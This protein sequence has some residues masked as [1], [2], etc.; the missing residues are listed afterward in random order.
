MFYDGSKR[1][2]PKLRFAQTYDSCVDEPCMRLLFTLSAA[3]GLIVMDADC[4]NACANAPS[5][6]QPPYVRFDRC[7]YL[8]LKRLCRYLRRTFDWGILYWRKDPCDLLPAGDFKT[9]SVDNKDLPEFPKF[10]N[11]L[12]LVAYVDASMPRLPVFT[13]L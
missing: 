12:E 5:P 3:I 9:L 4:T 10:S 8:A 11:L 13:A 7:H 6:T 2:A 1:A